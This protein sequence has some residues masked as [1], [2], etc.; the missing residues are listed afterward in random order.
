VA[1]LALDDD[2]RDAF[3]GH[4]DGVGVAELVWR[5]APA[6]AGRGGGAPELRAGG[7]GCPRSAACRTGDDAEQ[8]ADGEFEAALEPGLEF[9]PASVVHA[10]LASASALAAADEQRATSLVEIGLGERE[11]FLDS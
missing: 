9:L 5:E 7:R 4:L 6:H 11:R 1:E 3:A 8:R 2:Q 10:D